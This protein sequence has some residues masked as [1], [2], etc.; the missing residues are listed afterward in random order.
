M[1][2]VNS[3]HLITKVVHLEEVGLLSLVGLLVVPSNPGLVLHEDLHPELFL[4]RSGV[5]LL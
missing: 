3:A 1:F 2:T 4:H 5:V